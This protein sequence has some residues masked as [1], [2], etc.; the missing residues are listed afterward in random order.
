MKDNLDALQR[1]AEQ[2]LTG[3]QYTFGLLYDLAERLYAFARQ[4]LYLAFSFAL[5][6]GLQS[7]PLYGNIGVLACAG[8]AL[9]PALRSRTGATAGS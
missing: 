8:L 4:G 5:F 1:V 7:N 3:A 6:L 9:G 2:G